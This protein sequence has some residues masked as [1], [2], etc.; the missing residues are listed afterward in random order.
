MQE[1]PSS[2]PLP[3]RCVAT[4]SHDGSVERWQLLFAQ[5]LELPQMR[6]AGKVTST[7]KHVAVR[8]G[9]GANVRREM[10]RKCFPEG[11]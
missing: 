8:G 9:G 10:R 2:D 7:V 1:S 6:Q 5:L 4:P 11:S 3:T